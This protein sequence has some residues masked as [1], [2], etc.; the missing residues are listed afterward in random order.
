MNPQWSKIALYFYLAFGVGLFALE[1]IGLRSDKDRWPTITEMTILAIRWK[2]WIAI[3]IFGFLGWL[4]V[5]F[6][7]RI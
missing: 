3:I 5:H 2:W 1:I 7:R 6:A 4:F